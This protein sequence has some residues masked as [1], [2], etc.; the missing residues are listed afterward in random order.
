MCTCA[1][2]LTHTHVYVHTHSLTCTCTRTHSHTSRSSTFVPPTTLLS[3]LTPSSWNS[4]LSGK[5]CL[6]FGAASSV[7]PARVAGGPRSRRLRRGRGALGSRPRFRSPC[8]PGRAAS[9]VLTTHWG[10]ASRAPAHL[11]PHS[12]SLSGSS[13]S[14]ECCHQSFS[15]GCQGHGAGKPRPRRPAGRTASFLGDTRAPEIPQSPR[16]PRPP[17][18]ESPAP[19][20]PRIPGFRRSHSASRRLAVRAAGRAGPEGQ[21]DQICSAP[22]RVCASVFTLLAASN[23]FNINLHFQG[24]N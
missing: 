20:I 17:C 23:K 13:L 9:S 4:L 16:K 22:G 11:L 8:G 7:K 3:A 14:S 21:E 2:T 19:N 15:R 6:F 24:N 1:H 12:P 10:S 5:G 18:S